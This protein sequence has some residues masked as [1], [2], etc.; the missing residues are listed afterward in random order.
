MPQNLRHVALEVGELNQGIKFYEALGAVLIS[1]DIEQGAFIS[2][3]TGIN[4]VVLETCK[5]QLGEIVRIELIQQ[6]HPRHKPKRLIRTALKRLG[7]I[8]ITVKNI[9]QI[10]IL[11]T[12]AGALKH[13]PIV[14]SEKSHSKHA[15]RARHCYLYDPWGNIIHLAEDMKI[16][17]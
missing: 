16:V 1:R 11:L 9:E 8:S 14:I 12:S 2:Q 13:N 5:M 10:V 3:L 17:S 15:V 6:I 4:G 7:H